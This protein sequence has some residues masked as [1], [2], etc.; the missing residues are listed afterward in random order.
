MAR[1]LAV[2]TG[3]SYGQVYTDLAA[4]NRDAGRTR[5]A[6]NGLR[7]DVY[8]PVYQE[9]GLVKVKLPHWTKPTYT[10]AHERYGDCIVRTT[11]HVCTI[12]GG[13][14]RDTFDGRT[15]RSMFFDGSCELRERKAQSVWVPARTYFTAG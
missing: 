6:R 2:L 15:Y 12:V 13:E 1:A 10:E 11:K 7:K 3:E 5:S 4:A 8:E 14:L 9:Y